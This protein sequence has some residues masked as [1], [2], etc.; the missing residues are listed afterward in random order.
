MKTY[1]P[2][3]VDLAIVAVL[4]LGMMRGRKRGMSEEMLDVLK[5][6]SIIVVGSYLYEPVGQFLS[7]NSPF[8]LLSCFTTVYALV[9]LV[10]LGLFSM[11]KR[12]VG[13]K[14][15]E[16]DCF[17]DSEYY[18]GVFAGAFRYGCILLVALSFLHARY[19]SPGEVTSSRQT[20]LNDF[21]MVLF[22]F[23][24]VQAEIF[25]RS[26]LG[27]LTEEYLSPLMIEPTSPQ[28]KRLG[29]SGRGV[30]ARERRI[31]EILE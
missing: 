28:D 17:G 1:Q 25:K 15:V 18:L 6:V 31:N 11:V 16:S 4:I 27:T 26:I 10:F 8:S 24:E 30:R 2:S 3:W 20:Q 21:G 29:Q 9:I 5:W 7:E 23:S 12:A 14:L 19:Y 22:T 13:T